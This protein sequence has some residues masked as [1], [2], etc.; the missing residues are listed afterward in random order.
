AGEAG[1]LDPPGPDARVAIEVA[2]P[3]PPVRRAVFEAGRG[4]P[5]GAAKVIGG[6]TVDFGTGLTVESITLVEDERSE[7][8]RHPLFDPDG[9]RAFDET[10]F[11][12][13]EET[14]RIPIQRLEVRCTG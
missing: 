2:V 3:G 14:R 1:P 7:T 13:R 5:I 9:S 10:G 8:V 11:L 12:F 6:T 4:D